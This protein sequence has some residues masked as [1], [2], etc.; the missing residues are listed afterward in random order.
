MSELKSLTFYASSTPSRSMCPPPLLMEGKRLVLPFRASQQGCAL[1]VNCSPHGWECVA[2][3]KTASAW[4]PWCLLSFTSFFTHLLSSLAL[5]IICFLSLFLFFWWILYVSFCSS[6]SHKRPM[7]P[8]FCVFESS[9]PWVS[10]CSVELFLSSLFQSVAHILISPFMLRGNCISLC[11]IHWT[12]PSFWF[13]LF[14]SCLFIF[15][16]L[17]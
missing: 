12:A 8:E 11:V 5:C 16:C 13:F 7:S 15:F 14:S 3:Y 1:R 9:L 2:V 6:G 10:C 17:F 4:H